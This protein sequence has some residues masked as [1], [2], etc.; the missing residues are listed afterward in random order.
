MKDRTVTTRIDEELFSELVFLAEETNTNTSALIRDLLKNNIRAA[1]DS[2]MC[3]VGISIHLDDRERTVLAS[4]L[5]Q[6]DTQ[7]RQARRA[8]FGTG[9]VN[10]E[11]EDHKK[12][13]NRL[14]QKLAQ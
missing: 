14:I 5:F 4:A 11:L 9:V 1:I 7:T 8:L 3:S 12:V 6:L 10:M 13:I 2:E